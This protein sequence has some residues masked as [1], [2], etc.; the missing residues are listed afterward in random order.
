MT[1]FLQKITRP[2]PAVKQ[3]DERNLA[4]LFAS[5]NLFAL[6]II[7]P[8]NFDYF[9]RTVINLPPAQ[10][11]IFFATSI[12]LPFFLFFWSYL[13]SRS[14]RF[15]LAGALMSAGVILL[16]S[17]VVISTHVHP[18]TYLILN[19][20]VLSS[21][22]GLIALRF[23][24]QIAQLFLVILI[25]LG[26]ILAPWITADNIINDVLFLLIGVG[27]STILIGKFITNQET[28][29]LKTIT[30]LNQQLAE[31]NANTRALL[32]NMGE[33]V[34]FFDQN[35]K[36]LLMNNVVKSLLQR[37]SIDLSKPPAEIIKFYTEAEKPVEPA[38]ILPTN[39]A[40]QANLKL[41]NTK[42]EYI[43]VAVNYTDIVKDNNSIGSVMV[44]HD[45][46]KEREIEEAKDS[47]FNVISHELRTP[48][49]KI[50]WGLDLIKDS[51]KKDDQASFDDI[52][53]NA[54][55]ISEILKMMLVYSQ[56]ASNSA[57]V[58]F[59]EFELG[60]ILAELETKYL[61]LAKEKNITLS[62]KPDK[63]TIFACKEYLTLILDQ[64]INNAIRFT[65]IGGITL[66]LDNDTIR[67]SDTGVGIP[68]EDHDK[69]FTSYYQQG[70]AMDRDQVKGGLG[71]G[72]SL[73]KLLANKS[74][75]KVWFES[76]Q[77]KGST[78]FVKVLAQK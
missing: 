29:R 10:I 61:P 5:I 3:E 70:G 68:K 33:G 73:V 38:N 72:L 8:V 25:S 17:L 19:W 46:R 43:P 44:I 6:S 39:K 12:I 36:I 20:Y 37:D 2:H 4:R 15:R 58:H 30:L 50:R 66:E 59:E 74:N 56:A 1:G 35:K 21:V 23:R 64:Y 49:T 14:Q 76:E 27:G 42:N 60:P 28:T 55:R 7:V 34:V 45:S 67:V 24:W 31:K 71:I 47:F 62:I 32:E 9:F 40:Y 78:F 57:S 48:L 26:F 18:R 75:L 41:K 53:N 16:I 13:L 63:K 22:F 54:E 51:V 11:L 69:I 52:K 77:G 65:E